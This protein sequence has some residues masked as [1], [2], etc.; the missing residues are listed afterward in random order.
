MDGLGKVAGILQVR[1]AGLAPHQVGIRCVG[2]TPRDGLVQTRLGAEEAFDGTLAGQEGLVVV[3]HIGGDQV[4]CL[5]VGT[6]HQHGGHATHVGRQTGCDELGHGFTGGH[7]HLA[8]HVTA[9]LDGGQLVLEVDTGSAGIDHG[10][11]QLEGVEHATEA[12]LGIR[13]DGGEVVD[14]AGIARVLAL[15]PLD[16]VSAGE[17]VVDAADHLRDRVG[18]IE[19]LVGVHL[20][21]TVGVARHLPARQV[22]GLQ[23]GLDLLHGLVAGQRAQG[24]DEGLF[25]EQL[26][27]LFGPTGGQR[28]LGLQRTAQPHHGVCA[29]ATTNTAPPWAL[30]PFFL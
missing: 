12:C 19:R 6:S 25:V 15:G 20:A 13:H 23:A 18:R 29:I 17:R 30:R 14:V 24:V 10:L 11:H 5:G 22:D 8:A 28:V 4:G 16:L 27:E 1:L 7:Q 3:I 21:R 2:Q 9:L 26:P